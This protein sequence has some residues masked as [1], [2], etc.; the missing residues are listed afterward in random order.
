MTNKTAATRYARALLDVGVKEKA[1]LEQ[2]EQELAQFVDLFKQNPLLEKVLL[3][4]AVPV[5]RKRAAVAELVA[6][7]KPAGIV[8]K[9]LTLLA[10]RDRLVLLPD[11]VASYRERLLDYRKIVRAEVTTAAPL[12]GDRAKALESSLARVTGRSVVLDTRVDAS[13]IGGVVARVGSTV[14]DGSVTRQLEKI[15]ERLV[16]GV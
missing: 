6:R 3:N 1:D 5:P 15:K 7:A 11:L 14:Y 2:V 16:E 13:I 4:P 8:G 10:D 12:G 9:L